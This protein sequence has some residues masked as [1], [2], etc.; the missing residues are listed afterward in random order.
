[1]IPSLEGPEQGGPRIVNEIGEVCPWPYDSL[2]L[3]G[4]PMGQYHCPY[5][6]GMC[7]AGIP[8]PDYTNETI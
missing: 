3:V 2:L 1:M 6:G 7:V 8:H 4:A 5:C